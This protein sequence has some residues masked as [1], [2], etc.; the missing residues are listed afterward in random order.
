[1][2]CPG[3]GGDNQDPKNVENNENCSNHVSKG[4]KS[5]FAKQL[6]R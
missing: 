1:M 4:L 6:L 5:V 2:T 3:G